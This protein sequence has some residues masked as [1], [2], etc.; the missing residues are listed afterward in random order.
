MPS[1][2]NITGILSNGSYKFIT[3]KKQYENC[4]WWLTDGQHENR[5]RRNNTKTAI[6]GVPFDN[7]KT[8][9]GGIPMDNTKTAIGGVPFDNTKTA[10]G[11]LPFD[12]TKTAIGGVPFGPML[13]EMVLVGVQSAYFGVG[14]GAAS[15]PGTGGGSKQTPGISVY[16]A[17]PSSGAGGAL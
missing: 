16:F 11:G 13:A 3:L 17:A 12:N 8:A 10:I 1:M 6:G 14:G 7:T 5:Y 15:K 4:D 2:L 9:I